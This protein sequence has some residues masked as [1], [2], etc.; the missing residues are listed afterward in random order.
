[1]KLFNGHPGLSSEEAARRLSVDGP[2]VL[3][4]QQ[5]AG[6][7]RIA[8]SILAEPMI[9]LLFAAT[10]MY[11]FLGK[12]NEGYLLL[13]AI[14]MVASIS[15]FQM[16][17]SDHALRELG[18]LSE[19]RIEALR[20]GVFEL[21]PATA[22][23][24]GDL[25]LAEEGMNIPSDGTIIRAYDLSVNE[26]ALSG[27]SVPVYKSVGDKLFAGTLV[28][29]G[30]VY[31]EVIATGSST[32]LG[33]LGRSMESI[34]REKTLLQRKIGYLVQVMAWIGFAAFLTILLVHWLKFREFV[35]ALLRG[36]T[37]A[38]ALIPEEIPVAFASFMALGAMK[39]SGF[40]V[41]AK[42]PRTVESL[43]S[44]TVLCADKTGTITTELMELQTLVCPE[45][46]FHTHSGQQ[47]GASIKAL[48]RAARIASEP[49]PFDAMEA[50]ISEEYQKRF[51][52]Y[53]DELVKEYPLSG[54]PP[55]MTHIILNAD[56]ERKVAAKGGL[57]KILEVCRLSPQE[58]R[59]ME[60]RAAFYTSSGIRVL[61]VASSDFG[62]SEFPARQEE[63]EWKF[64]GFLCL[65][66]PPK[67]NATSVIRGFRE[68]GIQVKMI[69]GDYS[70]TARAIA[71][72]VGIQSKEILTGKEVQAM[73]LKELTSK[74]GHVHIFARMFP[75]A[76][77]K[78][79]NA[80]KDSGEIVAMTGDGVNDGPALKAAHI[81]VAMGRRGT[82]LARQAASLVLMNDDLQGMLH[83][84]ELGRRIFQNLRKAIS[85]IIS[86]HIPII[87]TVAV[88][89]LLGWSF[90]ELFS[91]VHIVFLELVMG[92]TCSIAFEN[93]PGTSKTNRISGPKS[94]ALFSF[95]E[96]SLSLMQGLV[97]SLLI[98]FVYQSDLGGGLPQEV[99]R[100][101]AFSILVF[102]NIL[103]TL[104]N[105]S[106]F[107]SALKT[108][109]IPNRILWL[110]LAITLG[111]L[112]S[113][114]YTPF[115]RDLFGFA[116]MEW[117]ELFFCFLVA[118]PAVL[119]VE[120]LKWYRRCSVL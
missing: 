99:I 36:L 16:V 27:E 14:L 92:P 95:R 74:V 118:L 78:V 65:F 100:T 116:S 7:W 91:P 109:L 77:L 49:R 29:S 61:G 82:E 98:L 55:M 97:I 20:S 15:F 48:L 40:H 73:D 30:S 46:E 12:S 96:L 2:N 71:S 89:L 105:R 81:G 37:I 68:A 104:V 18:K 53:T 19:P 38:M 11:F 63:F 25:L 32:E 113:A 6:Y 45:E 75:D 51:G 88:P 44:A 76:K 70:E 90:S 1:M 57:E 24:R 84:V 60:E 108:L 114:I 22:I 110:I 103:L 59:Q 106:F 101:R 119:W 23:V 93:E 111:I 80:L 13:S 62:E 47:P 54:S 3:V 83:A 112:L 9:L 86:I 43:G 42:D 39:L 94:D 10:L 67:E 85:Y 31:F 115:L 26:A 117:Q 66:N 21:I 72:M 8:T 50:A 4:S 107:K 41:L 28:S 79:I 102:S 120:L 58:A 34:S 64:L 56:N 35:P 5:S 69:T 33:K 17:K 87:L 52:E